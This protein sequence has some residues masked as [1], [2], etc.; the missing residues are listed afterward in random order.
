[1]APV[2]V[3][4]LTEGDSDDE[5]PA[6]QHYD[7]YGWREKIKRDHAEFWAKEER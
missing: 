5:K 2:Q 1:M 6:T 7:R 4:D 3:I